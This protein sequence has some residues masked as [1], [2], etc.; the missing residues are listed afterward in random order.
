MSDQTMVVG[1]SVKGDLA[2][3]E[4]MHGVV[5]DSALLFSIK[6]SSRQTPSLG[7]LSAL[8]LDKAMPDTHD[9][10]N[11]ARTSLLA[12][13]KVL[14]K[15]LNA[16]DWGVERV[17]GLIAKKRKAQRE[18][19]QQM[20]KGGGGATRGR[21]AER[22]GRDS[23]RGRSASRSIDDDDACC[24][25]VHRIPKRC[26]E[27]HLSKMFAAHV[28]DVP[29]KI[30]PIEFRGGSTGKVMVKFESK[31]QAASVFAGIEGKIKDDAG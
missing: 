6:D 14:G 7:D 30:P 10:A 4:I 12:L 31:E 18:Y 16:F 25:L 27:E 26:T 3:L 20:R 9:S 24:L 19:F 8:V 1:H 13:Q 15:D 29:A 2:A 11:D 5:A 22:S 17:P 23:N 21:S 28:G